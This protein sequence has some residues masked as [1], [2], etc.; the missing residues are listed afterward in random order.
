MYKSGRSGV[1]V[2]F[3]VFDD[4]VFLIERLAALMIDEKRY[5]VLATDRLQ[6]VVCLLVEHI[7]TFIPRQSRIVTDVR[8]AQFSQFLTDLRRMRTA[9][10]LIEFEHQTSVH[11]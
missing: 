2:P 3:K 10:C 4:G 5:L 9:F 6:F 11:R 7:A 8:D 1:V